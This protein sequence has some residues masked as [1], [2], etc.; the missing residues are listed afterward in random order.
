MEYISP[1]E[2]VI[3]NP[4]YHGHPVML[5]LNLN[6]PIYAVTKDGIYLVKKLRFVRKHYYKYFVA[7]FGAFFSALFMIAGLII[8]TSPGGNSFGAVLILLALGGFYVSWKKWKETKEDLTKKVIPA[9]LVVP[10]SQV[11][12]VMVTNI[13]EINTGTLLHPIIMEVGDW[14]VLT[15]DGRD[16]TIPEIDSPYDKLEYVKNR[17]GVKF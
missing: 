6:K 9:E 1:S 3:L 2:S 7:T 17:F 4:V 16:I 14:H 5:A 11:K 15:V 10:W 12:S 13:R 8:L